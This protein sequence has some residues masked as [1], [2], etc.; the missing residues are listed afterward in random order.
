MAVGSPGE[1]GSKGLAGMWTG[2]KWKA[3]KTPSGE[4]FLISVSCTSSSAC[5]AV[6]YALG[7]SGEPV[8][9]VETWN[10]TRWSLGTVAV[11][12]RSAESELLAVSCATS[13]ACV[14]V[15]VSYNSSGVAGPLTESWNG[16]TWSI[17]TSADVPGRVLGLTGVSCRSASRCMAI[18]Y[19]YDR[20]G[21]PSAFSET[22][23]GKKWTS[24]A[25]PTP[26]GGA[27]LYD[28]DCSSDSSCV[29]VGG[30]GSGVLAED[31]NGK[32]WTL[33]SAVNP[34]GSGESGYLDG[35]SC[36]SATSCTAVGDYA[37]SIGTEFTLAEVT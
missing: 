21:S 37:N 28:V 19:S 25:V 1:P 34:G 35:V 14:A 31:W 4:G 6:G 30:S 12:A 3:L 9:L 33:G 8:P 17:K 24:E 20:L 27:V 10:G 32:A 29:T 23:N 16:K 5:M 18:G 7:A 36:T 11:P 26:S 13:K 15:G 2:S 22:W